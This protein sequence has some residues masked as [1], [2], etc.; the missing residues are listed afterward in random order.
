MR[1]VVFVQNLL[2][3]AEHRVDAPHPL[4]LLPQQT[5]PRHPEQGVE[6]VRHVPRPVRE[7]PC[8]VILKN[9]CSK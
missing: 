2:R 9:W 1:H 5:E 4:H 6:R 8:L 3:H 7:P